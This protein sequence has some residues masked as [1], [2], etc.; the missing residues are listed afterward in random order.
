VLSDIDCTADTTTTTTSTTTTTL[1]DCGNGSIEG[2]EECDDGLSNDNATPGGCRLDCTE[3]RI[4]GDGDGSGSVNVIDAQWILK[5]AINLVSPC[6]LTACD[7]TSDAK[8]SVSDAQRVLFRSVGLIPELICA[9]PIVLRVDQAVL[10]GSVAFDVHYGATNESF[11]GAGVE[12][13]CVPLVSGANATFTNDC[14]AEAL[15]IDVSVPGGFAGPI[16]LAEC[17]FRAVTAKPSE[18]DFSFNVFDSTG[19]A[20]NPVPPPALDLDY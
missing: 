17:R 18:S 9:F 20:G 13:D 12:V 7:P 16:D 1:P 4:C 14:D 11:L 19:P 5:A 10:L 3:D 8:V 15:T 2:D 6:P